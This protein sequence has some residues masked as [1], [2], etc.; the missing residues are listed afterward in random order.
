M[1]RLTGAFTSK[2]ISAAWLYFYVHFVTEVICFYFLSRIAGDS[3]FLWAAPLF[4]DCFAFVPQ[5]LIGYISDKRPGICFGAIGAALMCAAGVGLSFTVPKAVSFILIFILCIGNAFTH[6]NGA[7]V[8]LRASGGKLAHSAIFVAGGSFGVISGKLL[9]GIVPPLS[10]CVFVL[11]AI[12]F[13]LL[14]EDKRRQADKDPLPTAGFDYA[15]PRRSAAFVIIV[16]TLI[17]IVRGYMGYGI[18]TSWKKTVLQNVALYVSMGIG[19]A[20]GGILSDA[21]GIKK[22]AL[23]SAA[24]ALPFL[25]FGDEL[26]MV[27]LVGVMF[28]SMTMSI[29]LA[30][31]VSV[32]KNAPGLA[33]GFTTLGLFLGTAPIF[34]FKFT[35]MRSNCV[36]ISALTVL[37]L[38]ALAVVLRKDGEKARVQ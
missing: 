22:T 19:K 6:V 18:P 37:C 3:P 32:L 35:S 26:M 25:L 15:D 38:I 4:Y 28:F 1:K 13:A 5:G 21:F 11:T 34:F 20:L 17:V 7:E 14:A 16:A 27:S 9:S 33:F 2:N 8:T 10:V 23:F 31:L 29:T 24:A 30:L 36:I 12:P